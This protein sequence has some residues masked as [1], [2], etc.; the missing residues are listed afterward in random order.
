MVTFMMANGLKIKHMV[1]AFTPIWMGLATK[2]IGLKTNNM[3]KVMRRGLMGQ[4]I[5]VHTKTEKNMVKVYSLG[6]MVLLTM[7]VSW[8]T[9]SKDMESIIGVMEEFLKVN[10]LTTKCKGRESSTGRTVV[11]MKGNTWTIRKRV[12]VYFTGLT[13]GNMMVSG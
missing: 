7:E 1:V 4:V 11:N 6:L 5:R 13:V 3:E 2:V 9:T 12:T 8:I 10:G